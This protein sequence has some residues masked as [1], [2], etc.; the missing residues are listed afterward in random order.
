MRLR[1]ALKH[2]HRRARP[3]PV[4]KSLTRPLAHPRSSQERKARKLRAKEERASKGAVALEEG[5]TRQCKIC[6]KVRARPPRRRTTPREYGCEPPRRRRRPSRARTNPVADPIVRPSPRPTLLVDAPHRQLRSFAASQG[7]GGVRGVLRGPRR[8]RR[9]RPRRHRA[10]QIRQG[11]SRGV[12]GAPRTQEETGRR[13]ES[14]RRERRGGDDG[15]HPGGETRRAVD[16]RRSLVETRQALRRRW[17]RRDGAFRPRRR[18]GRRGRRAGGRRADERRRRRDRPRGRHRGRHR[19]RAAARDR[20]VVR[21]EEGAPPTP[22]VR[23][24]RP[25][26]QDGG[27]HRRRLRRRRPRRGGHRLHDVPRQRTFPRHRHHHV[28]HA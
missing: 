12:E 24:R 28:R 6:G 26:L 13:D 25:L 16:R 2:H 4:P 21:G 5:G 19:G 3:T 27:G 11:A 23:R 7:Q 15:K 10:R 18:L 17:L 8:A 9:T 1:I 14:R 20:P 22:G